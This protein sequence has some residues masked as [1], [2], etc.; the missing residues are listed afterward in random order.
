M[1]QT[2]E[3]LGALFAEYEQNSDLTVLPAD[4]YTLRV[5]S[6]TVRNNGLLP[7]YKVEEG[8]YAGKR[9]MAGGIYPGKTEGGRVAFFRKLQKFGLGKD[10]FSQNPTLQDVAKALND[11]VVTIVLGVDTYQGE[12][13]NEMGFDITLV[14]A[15][16]TPVVGGSTVPSVAPQAAA[17]STAPQPAPTPINDTT[18]A[19]T[20]TATSAPDPGF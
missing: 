2:E 14:S 13:R 7:V 19:P 3:T 15:P 8:P 11:R 12:Q 10:F 16:G 5:T 17:T 4:R 6:C 1:A 20:P 18:P 9:V